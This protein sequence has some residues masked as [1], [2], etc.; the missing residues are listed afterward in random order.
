[1]PVDT[2]VVVAV[3]LRHFAVGGKA[4][5]PEPGVVFLP[6]DTG[7][8]APLERFIEVAAGVDVADAY[9]LPV[10]S[11]PRE[12]IGEELSVLAVHLARYRRGSVFAQFVGIEEDY[13]LC[14]EGRRHIENRLVLQSIV[15][16]EEV[17]TTVF[18]GQRIARV[19]PQ[20]RQTAQDSLAA[21][22]GVDV[23]PRERVLA[24][25]PRCSFRRVGIL[26]PAIGI[27]H[28][29][30]VIVVD[31]VSFARLGVV[32]LLCH[33]DISVSID[34]VD[35]SDKKHADHGN[36]QQRNRFSYRTHGAGWFLFFHLF[37]PGR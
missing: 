17:A 16:L 21:R 14:V 20:A 12:T 32:I 28:G 33:G 37:L 1:M 22:V 19:V 30:S 10:T 31:H 26:Q 34:H 4:I 2:V 29:G 15:S 7:E 23:A 9:F 5:V 11:A 3:F 6:A 24:F 36:H 8:L 18:L 27:G 25:D 13:R 35:D